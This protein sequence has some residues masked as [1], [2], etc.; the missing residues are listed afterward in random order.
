VILNLKKSVSFDVF[1]VIVMVC[2]EKILLS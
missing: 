1:V 2:N